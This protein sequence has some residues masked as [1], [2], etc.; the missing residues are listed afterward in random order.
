MHQT[1]YLIKTY[2]KFRIVVHTITGLILA[3]S[4]LPFVQKSTK[5]YLIKWWCS[6]LLCAF[7]IQVKTFGKP[8]SS[9]AQGVL[10]VANH[11]SW[12][13]IHALN[14]VV[15]LRFISKSDVKEWPIFGYLATQANTL[16]INRDNLQAAG[17]IVDVC[18]ASLKDG[19]NLCFFPEGTTSDGQQVL[20][21]KSS[22][23]QAAIDA[24]ALI[25][26]VAVRYV[27]ADASLNTQMAYAG[28]TTM[29]QSIVAILNIKKPVVELHFLEPIVTADQTRRQLTQTAYDAIVTKLAGSN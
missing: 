21:F 7:N 29:L 16:F 19:D 23:V 24:K 22:I 28:E 3:A 1:L 26:P 12:S 17:K 11:V 14:S 18:S 8:P 25:W 5:S 10:F 6:G 2:R 13:D 27:N 9:M 15:A 20:P 4:I